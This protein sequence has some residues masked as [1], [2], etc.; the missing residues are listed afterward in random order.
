MKNKGYK[1][2]GNMKNERLEREKCKIRM[3]KFARLKRE[4]SKIGI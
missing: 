4:K 1:T 2:D 3:R